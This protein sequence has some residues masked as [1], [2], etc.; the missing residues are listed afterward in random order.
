VNE[1]SSEK[2]GKIESTKDHSAGMGM[3]VSI[4]IN[5]VKTCELEDIKDVVVVTRPDVPEKE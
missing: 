5:D 1:D 3:V 2:Y 4:P